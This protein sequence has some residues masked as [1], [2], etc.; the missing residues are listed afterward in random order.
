[1]NTHGVVSKQFVL[2]RSDLTFLRKSETLI[3]II[4]HYKPATTIIS[5]QWQSYSPMLK[6]YS[7]NRVKAKF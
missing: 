4:E 2:A 5:D 3:C 6:E 1:M 7:N